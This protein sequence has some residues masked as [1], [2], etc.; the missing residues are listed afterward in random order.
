MTSD[1]KGVQALG[2]HFQPLIRES[3]TLSGEIAEIRKLKLVDYC[4]GIIEV[5]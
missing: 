4:I 5:A 3:S 1:K 2:V